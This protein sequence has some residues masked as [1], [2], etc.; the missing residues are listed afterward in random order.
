MYGL[1]GR[2]AC[3]GEEQGREGWGVGGPGGGVQLLEY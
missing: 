1:A 2:N 3:Y